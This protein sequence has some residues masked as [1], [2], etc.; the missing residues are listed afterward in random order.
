MEQAFVEQ[1]PVCKM[2][3]LHF[4]SAAALSLKF[5]ICWKAHNDLSMSD[6]QCLVAKIQHVAVRLAGLP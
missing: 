3:K 2:H 6:P 5:K 1:S 4:S